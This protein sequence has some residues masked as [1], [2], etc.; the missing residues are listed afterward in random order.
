MRASEPVAIMMFAAQSSGCP[1]RSRLD[2]ASAQQTAV[3]LDDVN[4]VL[5]HQE[6][7]A[8]GMFDTI[9]FLRSSTLG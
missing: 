4:L 2:L 3:S 8:F 9:L 5:P 7:D 6:L 1:C